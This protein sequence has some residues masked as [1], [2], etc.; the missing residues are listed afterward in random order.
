M[1]GDLITNLPEGWAIV[2]LSEIANHQSGNSALIKGKLGRSEGDGIFPAFSATGRDV[3][4]DSYEHEGRAIIISAVG[5]RCGKCFKTDGMWSAIANTHIV[6]PREDLVDRD[7]LWFKINDENFWV[8]GGSAQPFVKTRES[9]QTQF[10]LPPVQ[11][12]LRIVEKIETLFTQLDQG[13]ASLRTVQTLLTRYRQSVLKAAVTGQLTADWRAG[14]PINA[15]R[16][17][18][19]DELIEYLTSGSRGWAKYYSE[20]GDIF[21]RAQNIKY[22]RLELSDIAYVDLPAKSEGTRTQVNTGDL[23]VTITGANV[24]KTAL[25]EH[26]IGVAY[27]SQ[28]VALVRPTEQIRPEFLYW[29]LIADSGGRKQLENYAYGAGKPGL[30]LQNIR[31]V[32]I[33]LPTLDEQDEIV[34]RLRTAIS[35]QNMAVRELERQFELS[36]ALRQSILKDAFAGRLVPQDP[37]DEPASALLARI[38]A[39]RDAATKPAARGRGKA[40]PPT[41]TGRQA[42]G[43]L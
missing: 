33:S 20:S 17:T 29:F 18:T 27:V 25:V 9:F 15:W 13:E 12:Q 28:H 22:D 19:L 21:I 43:G 5:A 14:Q 7:F 30:N 1:M 11:E 35:N 41:S 3:W 10:L 36:T 34:R 38:R 39:E 32:R 6:W 40:R 24:T 42:K 4:M 31:D 16:T 8:R 2:T 37:N 23:L 26:D